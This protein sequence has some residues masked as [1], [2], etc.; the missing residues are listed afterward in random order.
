MRRAKNAKTDLETT[1]EALASWRRQHGGPGRRIPTALWN[2]ARELARDHGV[3]ET[4]RVLRLNPGR[5][6]AVVGQA[7]A[8]APTG[9]EPEAFVEVT[10]LKV[11]ERDSRAVVEFLGREGDCMRVHVAATAV[12]IVALAG[13]FW[14]RRP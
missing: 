6:G 13:A 11:G 12:D 14:G 5:L 8:V 1:R 10:G 3:A 2:E 7:L 9:V 4:A